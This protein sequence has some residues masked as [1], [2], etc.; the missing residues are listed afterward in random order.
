MEVFV[1]YLLSRKTFIVEVLTA[2]WGRVR[3]DRCVHTNKHFQHGLSERGKEAQKEAANVP[4]RRAPLG[5]PSVVLLEPRDV[6][7]PPEVTELTKLKQ[8]GNFCGCR[9]GQRDRP[10]HFSLSFWRRDATSVARWMSPRRR[11]CRGCYLKTVLLG[12]ALAWLQME[13]E[14][15]GMNGLLRREAKGG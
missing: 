8:E 13:H 2:G 5:T 3:R 12:Q 7:G 11:G 10:P 9:A 1:S 14:G 4:V 15:R 6:S